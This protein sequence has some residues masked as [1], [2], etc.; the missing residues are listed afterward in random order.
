MDCIKLIEKDLITLEEIK[1]WT[2]DALKEYCRRRGYKVTGTRDELCA[3][4]YFLYNKEVP[5]NPSDTELDRAN[6]KDFQKLYSTGPGTPVNPDRLKKWEHQ[7]ES[8]KLWPPISY[9]D[10]S[11]FVQ[12]YGCSLSKELMTSYKTGKAYSLFYNN[13]LKEVYYHAINKHHPCCYLKAECEH[14]NRVND[15]PHNLW[16]KVEKETGSIVAAYCTCVAGYVHV[17]STIFL[18]E[19]SY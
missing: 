6:K 10:I 14:S 11:V 5:E 12:K 9:V 7:S 13:Y 18:Q 16:V 8:I 4:A 19:I 2:T 1:L 17:L 3:R 15:P